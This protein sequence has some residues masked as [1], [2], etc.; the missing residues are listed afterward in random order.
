MLGQ[1]SCSLIL[2]GASQATDQFRSFVEGSDFGGCQSI[3]FLSE[4]AHAAV[5]A[6]EEELAALRGRNQSNRSAI[7]GRRIALHEPAR[8]QSIRNAT[9]RWRPHLLQGREFADGFLPH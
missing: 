9:H 2:G 1:A 8:Y 4:C 6:R 7:S 5:S 3:Q